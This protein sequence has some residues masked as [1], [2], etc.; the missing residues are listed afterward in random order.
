[1]ST[2]QER[3][4]ASYEKA[5]KAAV[6]RAEVEADAA[7]Q[8]AAKEAAKTPAER[9]AD[10]QQQRSY[11]L[12]FNTQRADGNRADLA[13]QARR[14]AERLTY[15]AEHLDVLSAA[16]DEGYMPEC[17]VLSSAVTSMLQDHT[18]LAVALENV[19]SERH[20]LRDLQAIL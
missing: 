17:P 10:L 14:M 6:L 16:A 20:L 19:R 5:N 2:R 8:R 12:D 7:R 15:Y 9:L 11:M 13:T 18:R 3:V 1:M 4:L